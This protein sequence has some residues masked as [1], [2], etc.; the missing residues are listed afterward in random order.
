MNDKTL[1]IVVFDK[2]STAVI[3]LIPNAVKDVECDAIMKNGY[4]IAVIDDD[5]PRIIDVGGTPCFIENKA[6]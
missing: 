6:N 1:S 4:D 2:D 5:D 3:A